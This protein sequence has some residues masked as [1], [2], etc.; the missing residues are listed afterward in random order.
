[1]VV[2]VVVVVRA[3]VPCAPD[4]LLALGNIS[5]ERT[6][7]FT[8]LFWQRWAWTAAPAE[9]S[10]ARSSE[11]KRSGQLGAAEIRTRATHPSTQET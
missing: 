11:L 2:V 5:L 6:F 10:T 4:I 8:T 1:M 9:G 7:A 3:S